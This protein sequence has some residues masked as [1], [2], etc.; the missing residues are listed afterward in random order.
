[1]HEIKIAENIVTILE[2]EIALPEVEKVKTVYL[3]VGKLRYIIPEIL[4]SSFKAVPKNEK[5]DK[6][7]IKIEEIPVKMKCDGCGLEYIVDEDYKCKECSSDKAE[8]ITGN[9]LIVKG[10]EW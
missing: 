7:E 8:M 9:E 3:E 10:I 5:L 4:I 2:K 1:M 6:A